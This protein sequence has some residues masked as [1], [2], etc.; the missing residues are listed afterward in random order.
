MSRQLAAWL[1]TVSRA[2]VP[3]VNGVYMSRDPARIPRGFSATC[4]TMGWDDVCSARLF[5]T[6]LRAR[7]PPYDQLKP[8][9]PAP[10][11]ADSA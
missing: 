2:A 1:V 6:L 5:R 4:K 10:F 9:N 11:H 8:R 3:E 7:R